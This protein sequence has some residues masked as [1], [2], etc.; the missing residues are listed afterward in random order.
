MVVIV[1][2]SL[3]VS[4]V[5]MVLAITYFGLTCFMPFDYETRVILSCSS[6]LIFF[7]LSLLS[8]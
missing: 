1:G 2:M 5:M 4:L 3:P 8:V 6:T 7:L